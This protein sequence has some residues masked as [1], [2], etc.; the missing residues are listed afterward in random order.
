[1]IMAD[2]EKILNLIRST[3]RSIE[4]TAGLLLF[5]SY[6]RNDNKPN[7]DIDLLVLIDKDV[8]TRE[9]SIRIT[10][11]LYDIEF[12][13]GTMINPLVYSKKFWND[14]HKATPFY[15]NVKREGIVL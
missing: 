1:M 8:V 6:A 9:D 13:T 4:P 5:G 15:E 2:K 12:A 3:V 11:P 10:Y 14:D 7:S